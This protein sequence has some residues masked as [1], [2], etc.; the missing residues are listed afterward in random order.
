M[1]AN[2]GDRIVIKG[3]R[4]GEHERDGEVLEVAVRMGLRLTSCD[5]TTT[6]TRR[7]SFPAAA[8]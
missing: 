4:L 3:Y 1:R 5:G 8:H 2:V 6:A 7:C